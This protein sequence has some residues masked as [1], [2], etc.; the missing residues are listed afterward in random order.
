MKVRDG[1]HQLVGMV[2]LGQFYDDAKEIETG[3]YCSEYK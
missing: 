2:E 1:K 3:I